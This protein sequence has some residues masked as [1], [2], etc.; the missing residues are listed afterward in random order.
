MPRQ[1]LQLKYQGNITYWYDF[2]AKGDFRWVK[3]GL[4]A[5][6]KL[7][8]RWWK[9]SGEHLIVVWVKFTMNNSRNWAKT[10]ENTGCWRWLLLVNVDE[11]RDSEFGGK[12]GSLYTYSGNLEA[13]SELYLAGASLLLGLGDL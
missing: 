4:E 13:S 5:L 9:I 2:Q 8:K 1:S 7:G 6:R 3:T 10:G 11:D 12:K